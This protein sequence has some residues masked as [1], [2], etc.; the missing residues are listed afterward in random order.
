VYLDGQQRWLIGT[1]PVSGDSASLAMT[2]T[3]GGQFPPAFNPAQVTREPWG[4]LNFRALDSEHARIE[5]QSQQPGYSSGGLDLLRLSG[6][7][8][9]ACGS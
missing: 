1:G 8:G 2:V 7:L 6:L 5:W 4:T 9:H 3:R